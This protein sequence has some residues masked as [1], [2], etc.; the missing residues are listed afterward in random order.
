MPFTPELARRIGKGI[1]A[2]SIQLRHL[3]PPHGVLREVEAELWIVRIQIGQL[4]REPAVERVEILA[5]RSVRIDQPIECVGGLQ[6]VLW[7]AVKPRRCRRI[8]GPGMMRAGVIDDVIDQHF[9]AKLMGVGDQRLVFLHRSHVVVERI[10]VDCVIAVVVGVSVLPDRSEP[11]RG[12]AEVVQIVQV[13][14]NAAQ[15]AAVICVRL[16]A[17]VHAGRAGR[18]VVRWIAIGEAVG[19]D[20][21]DDVVAGETFEAAAGVSVKIGAGKQRQLNGRRS[22]RS[23]QPQ[24][25]GCRRQIGTQLQVD[26]EI[27][28]VG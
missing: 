6:M 1:Q 19:H 26:E 16:I 3:S 18:L 14:A 8:V 27:M 15:I 7:R 28:S 2:E 12:Y 10:E 9:H 21:V 4:V 11:Q 24:G 5:R 25:Q 13:L 17:V 22:G 20:Q 23:D